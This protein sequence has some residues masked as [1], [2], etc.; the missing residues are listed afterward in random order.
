[1]SH[2]TNIMVNDMPLVDLQNINVLLIHQDLAVFEQFVKYSQHYGIPLVHAVA[3]E[4]IVEKE[5]TL[6]WDIIFIDINLY[7]GEYIEVINVFKASFP[8]I[9]VIFLGESMLLQQ[10]L[11]YLK[12]GADLML[13]NHVAQEVFEVVI[14]T[15]Y[16]NAKMNTQIKP[17]PVN[18]IILDV[19]TNQ[20]HMS[21]TDIYVALTEQEASI[22]QRF[23]LMPDQQ[24][25]TWQLLES[26]NALGSPRG[27][28][29]LEVFMS[30]LRKKL[31]TL[32]FEQSA[33]KAISNIGYRLTLPINIR[34]YT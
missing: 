20:L 28:K 6:P 4:H 21:G 29:N 13:S 14:Q 25:K 9:K 11:S 12:L 3:I 32:G 17:L 30:R 10:R 15:M 34:D 23:I 5:I 1:M 18:T 19:V 22:L 26:M 33:I 31:R 27:R 8:A 16:V 2:K 7:Q 24:L